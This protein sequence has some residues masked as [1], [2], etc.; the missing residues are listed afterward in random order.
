MADRH[1]YVPGPGGLAQV[2]NHFRSKTFPSSVTAD[3]LKKL[4][5]APKN[6]S[7]VLNVI[8]FL[9]LIDQDSNKTE[10]ATEVFKLHDDIAFAEGFSKIVRLAYADL[11][12]LHGDGS[13]GLGTDA[14]ITFFRSTDNTTDIVGKRQA[15]TF[16]LLTSFSGY[17]E[18]PSPKTAPTRKQSKMRKTATADPQKTVDSL[19][20][21]TNAK[22]VIPIQDARSFG[23]TVRVE[24]NLPADGDQGTYDRIF[25]SIKDNLLNG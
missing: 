3:T 14:L 16:R 10:V 5:F 6:E 11:F 23:L 18:V 1:P 13:W 24:I 25:K 7:Y 17:G 2:I 9:G 12:D 19:E 8:R 20:T 22:P 4:G 15:T 21:S